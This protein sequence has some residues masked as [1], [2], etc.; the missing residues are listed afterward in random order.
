MTWRP[1]ESYRRRRYSPRPTGLV[2]RLLDYALAAAILGLLALVSTRFDR[3]ATRQLA[4]EAVINDGDSITL[5]GERIRLRGIDAPEYMQTCERDGLTY[6]CGHRSREALSRLAKNG[7]VKCVGSEH[8]RYGRLLATCTAGGIELNRRQ[9]EEG[10]A[11]A[12]G[13]YMD[14][15]DSARE[16]GLGLWAGSFE[17]PRDWRAEHGEMAEVEPG[18]FDR[19]FNWLKAIFGF[20]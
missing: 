13:N 8:D 2:R 20:S 12:Y 11:V 5:K 15:E 6:P 16:R 1:A 9:V 4:G 17:R 3:V 7:P 18:A 10:W 19:I 14:A